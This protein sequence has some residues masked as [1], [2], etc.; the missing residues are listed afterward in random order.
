MV[1]LWL[2]L[3]ISVTF[4]KLAVSEMLF[5][6]HAGLVANE[7]GKKWTHSAIFSVAVSFL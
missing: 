7:T 1:S 6:D 5:K 3:T 4:F 2:L